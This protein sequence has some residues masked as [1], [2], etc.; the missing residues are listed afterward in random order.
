[1]A[2]LKGEGKVRWIGVSNFD[3]KQIRRAKAIAPVTSVQPPYSLIHREVR[4]GHS[5]LLPARRNRSDRL[6]TDGVRPA[7]RR[8]DPRTRGKAAER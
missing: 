4:R 2:D 1:M 7:H 5:A 3:V 8:N 6:F